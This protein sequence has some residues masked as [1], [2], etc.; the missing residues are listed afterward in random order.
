M[1]DPKKD[2]G[3]EDPKKEE[4]LFDKY[5]TKIKENPL[6]HVAIAGGIGLVLGILISGWFKKKSE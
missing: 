5:R 2:A 6:T 3:T 1:A 4:S